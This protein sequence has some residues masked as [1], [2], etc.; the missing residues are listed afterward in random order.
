MA[1]L[2]MDFDHNEVEISDFS[3]LPAGDYELQITEADVKANSKGTGTILTFKAEVINPAEHAGRTIFG[4][5]N[6]RHD[7]PTA[8]KI[9]QEQLSALCKSAGVAGKISNSD[10]LLYQ[11]FFAAVAVENYTSN[12]GEERQ[13]NALKKFHFE[14]DQAP[15]ANKPAPAPAPTRPAAGGAAAKPASG[16]V[17]L[18]WKRNAA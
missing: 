14:A 13:R 18:P 3:P 2:G 15:P 10:Q 5:L 4:N 8:Q 17:S 7:N 6:I 16:G 12:S 1:D 11:P 9:G